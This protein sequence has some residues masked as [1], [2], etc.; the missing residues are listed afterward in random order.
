MSRDREMGRWRVLDICQ[1]PT[2]SH[3]IIK[4]ILTHVLS[5]NRP[6]NLFS[7]DAVR[8]SI[9]VS[10]L[11][12]DGGNMLPVTKCSKLYQSKLLTYIPPHEK[13]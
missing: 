9:Q 7:E 2:K 8:A 11:V 13:M 4:L 12:Q 6:S 3:P 5:I 10:N 1:H